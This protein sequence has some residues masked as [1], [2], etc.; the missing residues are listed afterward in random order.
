[1][2][3]ETKHRINKLIDRLNIGIRDF[4]RARDKQGFSKIY[5]DKVVL[6]P[7]DFNYMIYHIMSMMASP[8]NIENPRFRGIKIQQSEN[9]V[10]DTFILVEPN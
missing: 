3:V 9:V 5:P 10:E 8:V 7:V 4:C 6:H 1:M 2:D